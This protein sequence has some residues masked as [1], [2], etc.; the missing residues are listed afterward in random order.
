[1][2]LTRQRGQA[3]QGVVLLLFLIAAAGAALLATPSL[4]QPFP[5]KATWYESAA[6]FPR[7]ALLLVVLAA[8]VEFM[9]RRKSQRAGLKT[10]GSDELDSSSAKPGLALAALGLFVLYA[11][12]VPAIGFLVSTLVFLMACGA[13]LKLAPRQILLLSVPLALGLWV[14]FVKILKVAFGHGWLV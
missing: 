11:L 13:M 2:S 1:M 7:A 6:S 8:V 4:I 3:V 12:A 14:V 5:S 10:S 9:L